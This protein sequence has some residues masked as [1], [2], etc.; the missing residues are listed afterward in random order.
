[1]IDLS[2]TRG[3]MLG[4]IQSAGRGASSPLADLAD[5]RFLERE[6]AWVM[7]RAHERDDLLEDLEGP[8]NRRYR[9][10]PRERLRRELMEPIKKALGNAYKWGNRRDPAKWIGVEIVATRA[11]AFVAVS[12]EGDGFDVRAL[13]AKRRAGER[14]FTHGGSGL[15]HFEKTASRVGY[16][17]QGRTVMIRFLCSAEPG[18]QVDARERADLGDAASEAFMAAQIAA[19]PRFRKQ[20]VSVESCRVYASSEVGDREV[21]RELTYAVKLR[22]PGSGG[23]RTVLLKGRLLPPH[24]GRTEFVV[25]HQL[26]NGAFKN[27]ETMRVPKPLT[28]LDQPSIVLLEWH[29]TIAFKDRVRSIDTPIR[30][31]KVFTAVGGGLRILHASQVGLAVLETAEE[32]CERCRDAGRRIESRL[33]SSGPRRLEQ[34]HECVA[35]VVRGFRDLESWEYRPVYGQLRWDAVTCA[36]KR[37]YL[38]GFEHCRLSHPGLDLGG[39]LADAVRFYVLREERRDLYAHVRRALLDGY[40]ADGL[41]WRGDIEWFVGCALLLGL[42][43]LVARPEKKWEPKV[44]G[45][46]G[47]CRRAL[48]AGRVSAGPNVHDPST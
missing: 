34:L 18:R 10:V 43:R 39:F 3:Q 29:P 38:N 11:G 31:A 48:L 16:E 20:R 22:R 4:D 13:V 19:V 24:L 27:H 15:A 23:T 30:L 32:A 47:E 6:E 35:L 33:A 26:G 46:L 41:A 2:S 28:I 14:Y 40:A 44:D 25:S 12:D 42:D 45:L 21:E 1:M 5:P 36:R 7:L 9:A 8:L 37:F 17:N